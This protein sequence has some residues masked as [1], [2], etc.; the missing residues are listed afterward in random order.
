[1]G[2]RRGVG[3]WG[4]RMSWQKKEPC[5]GAGRWGER[6]VFEEVCKWTGHILFFLSWCFISSSLSHHARKRDQTHKKKTC[7]RV[8]RH[9]DS[10][11]EYSALSDRH[12]ADRG[13][14]DTVWRLLFWRIS[15]LVPESTLIRWF[16]PTLAEIAGWM[17]VQGWICNF[18]FPCLK[19]NWSVSWHSSDLALRTT[20]AFS[21]ECCITGPEIVIASILT[22]IITVI[23][24]WS[25]PDWHC[26]T[27]IP[28][29]DSVES[30]TV[31]RLFRFNHTVLQRSDSWGH[32]QF[33]HTLR[34]K[35]AAYTSISL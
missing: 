12:G 23:R 17:W 6:K 34:F 24:M 3:G 18:F 10:W 21:E 25:Q 22:L 30:Q 2:G 27:H 13:M 1:M 5:E 7:V 8:V 15:P 19:P 11:R 33:P 4:S 9:S 32:F 14:S 29:E 16:P 28:P 31:L 35:F 20:L 26:R